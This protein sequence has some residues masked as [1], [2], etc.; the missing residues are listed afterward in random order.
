MQCT[1]WLVLW[2]FGECITTQSR[3]GTGRGEKYASSFSYHFSVNRTATCCSLFQ[4]YWGSKSVTWRRHKPPRDDGFRQV[5]WDPRQHSQTLSQLGSW[6]KVILL[7]TTNQGGIRRGHAEGYSIIHAPV[8]VQDG[9][10]DYIHSKSHRPTHLWPDTEKNR[11]WL[12]E[13]RHLIK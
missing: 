2:L 9:A 11:H 12:R 8:K 1:Q 7:S 6:W 5:C 13:E 10:S 4:W 3:N